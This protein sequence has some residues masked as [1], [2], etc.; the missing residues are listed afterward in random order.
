VT[1]SATF[2]GSSADQPQHRGCRRL[3]LDTYLYHSIKQ[4]LQI[5]EEWLPDYIEQRPV[6]ALG[7]LP[8]RLFMPRLATIADSSADVRLTGTLTHAAQA[9]RRG[10][11]PTL[12][13]RPGAGTWDDRPRRHPSS[14]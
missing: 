6:D 12:R 8:P 9:V 14:R 1:R 13:N 3:V 11:E 2:A 7:S 4:V 5:S 10:V